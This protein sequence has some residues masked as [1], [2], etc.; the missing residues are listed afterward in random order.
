MVAKGYSQ[1]EGLDYDKTF[2][3][4]TR[5][6]SLRL[7]IDLA[8]H[9]GLN[10]D[11]LDIKSAFLNGDLVEEIWMVPTPGISLDGNIV[12][13]D[14][15]RYD[16]MQAPLAWFEKLS[17]ALAEIGFISLPFYSCVFISADYKIIVV[18]YVDDITTA[19][20]RSYLKRLIDHLRSSFK[21]M[22][23]GFLQYILGIEINH[24][25]EGKELTQH[26]YITNIL[27]HF[28]MDNCRPVL[29]PIDSNTSLV[30]AS[31]SDPVFEQNSY[32]RMI[33]SLIYLVTC[34]LSHL[35]FSVSYLSRLSSHPLE[36]HHTAL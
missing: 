21:V 20:S 30:K 15:A 11:Q 17:E 34:T 5:Y 12:R 8:T 25:A 26:Q 9:L 36:R 35:A 2:A 24:T 10:T 33:G 23:K 4:V 1:I 18:V 14:K 31:D 13:L 32:Q 3:L 6:D 27:S 16:L 22:V 7:I 28:G 29:T 19:R